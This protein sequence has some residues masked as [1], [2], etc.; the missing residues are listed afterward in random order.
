[1]AFFFIRIIRPILW[2][3]FEF[4]AVKETFSTRLGVEGKTIL[5]MKE[6]PS[7]AFIKNKV[8]WLIAALPLAF[9]TGPEAQ[10][11]IQPSSSITLKGTSTLHD[12]ECNT[13]AFEGTIAINPLNLTFTAADISI[14]VL[15]IHSG[16]SS[17]DDKMYDAL[18]ASQYPK[19][20]FSLISSDS[21]PET[22]PDIPDSVIH[23]QGTLTIAGKQKRINLQAYCT[24]HGN[25]TL[26]V[27][28]TKKLL[29]TDFGIDPPTFMLGVLK[30]GNEVTVEFSL[31]LKD[32]HP[33]AITLPS[34]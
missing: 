20:Q 8:V 18:K 12:Y 4:P 22:R 33:Q 13:H 19:I 5:L 9:S 10:I 21:I 27:H 28:G 7:M 15:E 16:N 29:M 25:G 11:F 14:P 34:Q 24:K 6:A 3:Y 1:L 2:A 17:L 31:V 30:T 23:V 32:P 26:T